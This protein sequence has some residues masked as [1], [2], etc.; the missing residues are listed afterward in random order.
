MAATDDTVR[1]DIEHPIW[2][3]F[4]TIA[5]LVLI[6]TRSS[7]GQPDLAPKHMVMPLGWKNYFGFVCTPRHQTWR[8]IEQTEKFSVSYPRPDQLL[9]TSLAA[10]PRCDDDTKPILASLETFESPESGAP[11]L[12]NSYLWLDCSLDR[13]VPDF[14]ENGI[15]AGRIEAA[16]ASPEALIH[17]DM[18]SDAQLRDAPLFAYVHPGRFAVI[19]S[20]FSFPFPSGMKK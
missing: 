2:E 6:G 4:F 14:G 11:C 9:L 3:R 19:D 7:D 12:A 15:I 18:G 1:L 5:P 16:R 13:I 20:S 10:S 8:N 17:S